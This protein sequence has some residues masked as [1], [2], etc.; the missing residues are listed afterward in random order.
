MDITLPAPALQK[1]GSHGCY[2]LLQ[3]HPGPHLHSGPQPQTAFG[4]ACCT[5][6]LW[7]PQVQP[8]PGQLAQVHG[9]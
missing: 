4:T 6:R 8:W 7:Q 3:A 5:G 1:T 2:C 9:V